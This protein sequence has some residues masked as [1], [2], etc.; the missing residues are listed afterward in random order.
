MAGRSASAWSSS[1][2]SSRSAETRRASSVA[3]ERTTTA[4]PPA[5]RGA[6]PRSTYSSITRWAFEPPAPNDDSPA[7]R[8][9]SRSAPSSRT[10][11][12]RH[13]AVSWGTKNGVAAK[14]ISGFVV[15]L[16]RLLTMVRC[17]SCSSTLVNPAMPAALS[18]WPMFDLTEPMAQNWRS[19][20]S[21]PNALA[22][23]AISIGSPRAVPVPCAST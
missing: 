11:G 22:S 8:G 10:T 19:L 15:S 16:C 4:G 6:A 2:P 7:I 18:Q 1:A 20:V 14:S 9:T 5:A 12:R 21:A 13:G 17:W 3:A 23:P